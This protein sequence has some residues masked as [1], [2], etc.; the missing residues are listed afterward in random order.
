M[1]Q[2]RPARFDA[3]FAAPSDAT[4]PGVL[5]P[6]GRG[7]ASITPLAH[8]FHM[9]LTA[10]LDAAE[11]MAVSEALAPL[12][13]PLCRAPLAVDAVS[14]FHQPSGDAP[15]RLLRRYRLAG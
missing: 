15:F 13:A 3:S 4:R 6:L 1:V 10:R 11:G 7:D 12:V 5:E 14:L 2:Y 9:T 8:R